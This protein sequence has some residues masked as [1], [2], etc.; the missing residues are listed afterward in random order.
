MTRFLNHF[1]GTTWKPPGKLSFAK[2]LVD[3]TMFGATLHCLAT[4]QSWWK[5]DRHFGMVSMEFVTFIALFD[6]SHRNLYL[7]LLEW[8]API[9]NKARPTTNHAPSL[10]AF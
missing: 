8:F 4:K 10:K 1:L 5:P 7:Y 9:N 2:L 3:C 6:K